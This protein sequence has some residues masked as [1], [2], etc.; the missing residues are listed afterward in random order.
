MSTALVPDVIDPERGLVEQSERPEQMGIVSATEIELQ[1]A[2]A[3]RWPRSVSNFFKRAKEMIAIDEETADSCHYI[4]DFRKKKQDDPAIEGPSIRLAEIA[5]A[6]WGN[7]RVAYRPLEEGPRHVTAEAFCWDLENNTAWRAE[8]RKTI[9]YKNGGRY[10]EDMINNMFAVAGSIAARNAIFKAVPKAYINQL[11]DYAVHV[12][13]GDETT[14]SK[15]REA[16]LANF[17]KRGVTTEQVCAFLGRAGIEEINLDDLTK[18]RGVLTSIKDGYTTVESVFST[19][20]DGST[21]ADKVKE[22]LSKLNRKSADATIVKSV[23]KDIVEDI[24]KEVDPNTGETVPP[25]TSDGKE[26]F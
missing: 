16:A 5:A 18:L 1:I 8:C 15:R 13:R 14:L 17:L 4:L 3:R 2:T 20:P 23:A 12:A 10:S 6:C 9:V 26:P 21:K 25:P 19:E 7:L 22:G 11:D 24:R